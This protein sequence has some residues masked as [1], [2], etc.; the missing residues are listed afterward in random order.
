MI[1]IDRLPETSPGVLRAE[2]ERVLVRRLVR[3]IFGDDQ[4]PRAAVR[5]QDAQAG[6]NPSGKG[7]GLFVPSDPYQSLA[8]GTHPVSHLLAQWIKPDLVM[9]PPDVEVGFVHRKR[10]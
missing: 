2:K 1:A 8:P 9:D 3:E 5:I 6:A 7:H 10:R 4:N